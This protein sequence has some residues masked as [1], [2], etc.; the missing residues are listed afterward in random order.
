MMMNGRVLP[1][2]WK[3]A[4]SNRWGNMSILADNFVP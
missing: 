3:I 1:P 4:P 2:V